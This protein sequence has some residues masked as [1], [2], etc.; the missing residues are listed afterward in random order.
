[1]SKTTPQY[2]PLMEVQ[3]SFGQNQRLQAK[4]ERR[5]TEQ[6]SYIYRHDSCGRLLEVHKNGTLLEK[7]EYNEKGQRIKAQSHGGNTQYFYN[8]IGQ[9]V[10]AG[11]TTFTYDDCGNLAQKIISPGQKTR[12]HYSGTALQHVLLPDQRKVEFKYG[13]EKNNPRL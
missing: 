4:Q 10:R 11:N 1:M 6:S 9:L 12:Y 13:P 7:Y 5:G 2:M 3:C 8:R